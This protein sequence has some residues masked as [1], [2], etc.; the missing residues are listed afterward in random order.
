MIEDLLPGWT[1]LAQ[2]LGAVSYEPGTVRTVRC[3]TQ[4]KCSKYAY[5]HH[6]NAS[7]LPAPAA[8]S[9]C[10]TCVSSLLWKVTADHATLAISTDSRAGTADTYL[11]SCLPCSHPPF[12]E[13]QVVS[14]TPE[15]LRNKA[16]G[17]QTS[18]TLQTAVLNALIYCSVADEAC[19]AVQY[20]NGQWTHHPQVKLGMGSL[21][22]TRDLIEQ[23]VRTQLLSLKPNGSITGGAIAE[24]LLWDEQKTRVQGRCLAKCHSGH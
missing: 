7:V 3:R 19:C 9:A 17:S 18:V 14:A 15:G 13:C 6:G 11:A 5:P 12:V 24:S 21:S 2:E 23:S 1:A 8:L 22:A 16:L 4:T 10:W 20:Y